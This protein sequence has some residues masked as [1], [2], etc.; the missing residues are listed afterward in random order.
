MSATF[1]KLNQ[2]TLA[3]SDG[4]NILQAPNETGKSTW[5]AFLLSMGC[6]ILEISKRLG[7]NKIEVTLNYYSHLYPNKQEQ[8]ASRLDTAYGEDL[9]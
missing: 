1:G 9:K 6:S 5:C 2:E 4:L 3:L 7:H 8:L